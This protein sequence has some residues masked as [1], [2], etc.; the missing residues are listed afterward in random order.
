MELSVAISKRNNMLY[1]I[2]D[3]ILSQLPPETLQVINDK[4]TTA[5]KVLKTVDYSLLFKVIAIFLLLFLM[6]V[7]AY[8]KLHRLNRQIDTLNRTLEQRVREEVARSRE[9]DRMVF[10][11]NRLAQMGEMISMIAHQW[12]Q[13]LNNLS[14]LNQSLQHHYRQG[15][16]TAERLQ[17]FEKSSTALI[18]Q[19]SKTIDDFRNFFRPDKKAVTFTLDQVV[20]QVREIVAPVLEK[21][22]IRLNIDAA[23]QSFRLTG[24]PNELGQVLL[25]LINNAKDAF[26]NNNETKEKWIRLKIEDGKDSV[27]LIVEDNAGGIPAEHIDKIF[28]PYFSTKNAKNGTG[29]GLYISRQIVEEHMK[30]KLWAANTEIG[31]RFEM[32][33]P[34][35][36]E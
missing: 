34:K 5:P 8:L 2:V 32:I 26:E 6:G 28:D 31:A 15:R 36:T 27:R 29:L 11:Q 35:E 24:Y 33:F 12:R 21:K 1:G 25:N 18:R 14:I 22:A 23:S 7:L 10:H 30:G 17:T 20:E 16:L 3:K 9:K 19:M 13:P 4:W